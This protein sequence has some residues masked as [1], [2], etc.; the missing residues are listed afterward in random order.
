MVRKLTA[1]RLCICAS[2]AYLA[3]QGLP[4]TLDDV[5]RHS[6]IV[7]L[8]RDSPFTWRVVDGATQTRITPPPT[9]EVGDGD[10]IIAM[11]L[12]GFGLSQLP[13]SLVSQHVAAGRLVLVL[14]GY[15]QVIVPVQALWPKARHLVPRVR[16]VVDEL[17]LR[18]LAGQLSAGCRMA[19]VN[20]RYGT[21]PLL[22]IPERMKSGIGSASGMGRERALARVLQPDSQRVRFPGRSRLRSVF[23]QPEEH[24]PGAKCGL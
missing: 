18:A 23:A 4:Q 20:A 8:R 19:C 1:H 21:E 14:D 10:G 16:Y 3:A 11:T 6:C 13:L 15:A 7:N 22:V 2:P 12:A 24:G 9:H 5:S 17:V